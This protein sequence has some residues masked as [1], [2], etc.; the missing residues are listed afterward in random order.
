VT[1]DANAAD[2]DCLI[3]QGFDL[4]G[5]GCGREKFGFALQDRRTGSGGPA[6]ALRSLGTTFLGG[7][8]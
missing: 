7:M 5:D 1:R 2:G 4:A 8:A 3:E 6:A